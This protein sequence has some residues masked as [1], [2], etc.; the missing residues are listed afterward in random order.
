MTDGVSVM[1]HNWQQAVE[2][3]GFDVRT[4]AGEGPVDRTVP[5]LAIDATHPPTADELGRVLADA[6]LVV[7]ENLCSL[8]LNLPAARVTAAVLAGRPTIMHHHD[9]PWQRARF[10]HVGELPPRD[11]AWCHVTI[12]RLTRDQM[13]DRGFEATCI[14][15]GFPTTT[16]PGDRAGVR[17]A[18]AVT[19]HE[20]LLAHP[21]R[22]IPR[23][24]VA[25]AVHLAE[26][27]D[28]T[29][30][31]WGRAEDG[32][33]DELAE[34]LRSAAC[35]VI[36]GAPSRRSIDLYR[37][38]DAVLFPSTWEGFGN[39]PVEAA[40][41]LTPA[42]VGPYPV[43]DELRA[44]GFEWYPTDDPEPLRRALEHGDPARLEHN[45]RVATTH[46]SLETMGA[47]IADLLSS[48][49]WLP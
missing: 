28:G 4:V 37:A 36:Q 7:V 44:L 5:G 20:R 27:L 19:E 39:P 21:V 34:I 24:D 13:A 9:T 16:G 23:K 26:Q 40:I 12:N 38:A 48:R 10:A 30:W 6:D 42:A 35:P 32:Y 31:L 18:L 3:L 49:G 43:A 17:R 29:Y 47:A 2:R 41:H 14:Y 8:P 1:A 25:A 33:D 15:N 22:A 46:L 11:P 45:R